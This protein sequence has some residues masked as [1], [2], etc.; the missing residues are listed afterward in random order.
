MIPFLD[1]AAQHRSIGAEVER[2]ILDVVR[3]GDCSTNPA[4]AEFEDAFAARCGARE[5]IAV[6]AGVSALHVAL[7]AAGIGPGD[8]VITVSAAYVATT[9][10]ILYAGARPVFVD[11]DPQTWTMDPSAIEP[12][13]TPATKA[14]VPVH[15]HGRL[16]DMDRILPIARRHRLWVIEDA[17]QAH[18]AE[19]GSVAAGTF[20]D[21]GCFSFYPGKILSGA[22]DGGA[23]VTDRPDLADTIRCL[24]DMGQGSKNNHIRQGFNYR[25]DALQAAVLAAKLRYLDEWIH[26]RR[27]IASFY[28]Q[29]FEGAAIQRP[30]WP[31]GGDHAYQIYAIRIAERNL[32]R[33][34]LEQA[35]IATAIHYPLPVHLQPAY[36]AVGYGPGRLPVS[37]ALS[38]QTLSLPIYP[39]LSAAA[40]ERIARAVNELC[41][42]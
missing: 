42:P 12:A 38:A 40:V 18:G 14:I 29:A 41:R 2:A 1:P 17:A 28:D 24:R 21:M 31:D 3:S 25:M 37:E 27:R 8:E 11:I 19:R 9:A 39:E 20:G 10:A 7:L 26:A 30:A 15:L 32:V 6:N 33:S 5:A 13:L 4:I 23:V 36:A 35:G 22:G 16:A 34:R